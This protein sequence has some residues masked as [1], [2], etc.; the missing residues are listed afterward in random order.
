MPR[1]INRG[2]QQ[3]RCILAWKVIEAINSSS[4]RVDEVKRFTCC[5]CRNTK[6]S[7]GPLGQRDQNG[8]GQYPG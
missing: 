7:L 6:A 3:T 5:K 8:I 1:I 4:F 2:R